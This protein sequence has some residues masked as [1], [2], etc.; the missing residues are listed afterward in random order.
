MHCQFI[1]TSITRQIL[2]SASGSMF[3][4]A[5]D[6]IGASN[7]KKNKRLRGKKLAAGYEDEYSLINRNV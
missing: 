7:K 6:S 3:V 5:V 4:T 2:T 1:K